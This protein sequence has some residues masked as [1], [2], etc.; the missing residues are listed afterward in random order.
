MSSC[1]EIAERIYLEGI[2]HSER[3]DL[4]LVFCARGGVAGQQLTVQ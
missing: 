1:P 3:A 4:E 2:H